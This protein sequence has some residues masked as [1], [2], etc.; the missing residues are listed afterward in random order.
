MLTATTCTRSLAAR[1]NPSSIGSSFLHGAHHEAQKVT[2]VTL[3][4]LWPTSAAVPSVARPSPAGGV[5][6]G[7]GRAK[8]T[9]AM[10]NGMAARIRRSVGIMARYY[11]AH[12][13]AP[14]Q[15]RTHLR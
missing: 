8:A 2:T 13:G 4:A 7:P 11:G 10:E 14:L 9:A 6:P 5:S 15:E 3:P 1:C 12:A